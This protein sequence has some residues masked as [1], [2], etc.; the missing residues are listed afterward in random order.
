MPSILTAKSRPLEWL[1]N[2]YFHFLTA[3]LVNTVD[4]TNIK[5]ILLFTNAFIVAIIRTITGTISHFPKIPFHWIHF[6]NWF[7]RL[8]LLA[9]LY[10]KALYRLFE[11]FTTS[12]ERDT[13]PTAVKFVS[14]LLTEC[15]FL[16]LC[17][18]NETNCNKKTKA[19]C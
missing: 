5:Q 13:S 18:E 3:L 1:I 15:C 4:W 2:F 14:L 9:P 19:R 17:C 16:F 6:K 10:L 8:L 7:Y 11:S 12:T